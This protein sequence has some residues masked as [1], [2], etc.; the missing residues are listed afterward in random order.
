MNKSYYTCCWPLNKLLLATKSQLKEMLLIS[1]KPNVLYI[2]E[3]GINFG[4]KNILIVTGK[5]KKSIEDQFD[6]SIEVGLE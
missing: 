6:R 2:I 1:D 5:N 4:I 3:E